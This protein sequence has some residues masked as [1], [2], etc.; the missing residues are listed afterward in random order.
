MAVAFCASPRPL[1]SQHPATIAEM[2]AALPPA[3]IAARHAAL[4][5]A[6]LR[7]GVGGGVLTTDLRQTN[8]FESDDKGLAAKPCRWDSAKVGAGPVPA[9]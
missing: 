3:P 7:G 6:P 9:R 4:P 1:R 8:N 2:Y 5:P